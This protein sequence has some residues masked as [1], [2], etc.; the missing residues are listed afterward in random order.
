[1]LQASRAG[2]VPAVVLRPEALYG[3]W[4]APGRLVP[5][6]IQAALTGGE[7]TLAPG[8][9]PRDLL[10]VEDL[11][12][13]CIAAAR[14]PAAAGEVFEL[15]VDR[16]LTNHEVVAEVELACGE[17]IHLREAEP[18]APGPRRWSADVEKARRLLGWS[19]R[20]EL[21]EGLSR[22]MEWLLSHPERL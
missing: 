2:K 22:T 12:E 17:S 9:H 14:S 20:Y 19:P 13:A 15:G 5:A 8:S 7:L 1:M 3:P 10:Y 11:V 21:R 4:D 18:S 16:A 6:A